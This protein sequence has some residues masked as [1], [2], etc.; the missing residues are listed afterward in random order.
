MALGVVQHLFRTLFR[1]RL[2][3][4]LP[5]LISLK[6]EIHLWISLGKA[7]EV[8]SA[9]AKGVS[10]AD[11]SKF[12]YVFPAM[13]DAFLRSCPS[14]VANGLDIKSGAHLLRDRNGPWCSPVFYCEH[15]F[16]PAVPAP[17]QALP[18]DDPWHISS[19]DDYILG[20]VRSRDGSTLAET[21]SAALH[22]IHSFFPPAVL[23]HTGGKDPVSIKKLERGAAPSS[24]TK[25]S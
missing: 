10:E 4:S 25:K 21:A 14:S 24:A 19:V 11:S 15:H 8:R 16:V 18:F 17:R 7:T 13:K 3:R 23:G 5:R 12:A 22:G 1:Q 2:A 9:C 20:A 6:K